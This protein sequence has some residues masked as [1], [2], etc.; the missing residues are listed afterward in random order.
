MQETYCEREMDKGA[1]A[2]RVGS[3]RAA[4]FPCRGARA[5][6]VPGAGAERGRLPGEGPEAGQGDWWAALGVVM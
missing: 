5:A 2:G 4:R 1:N 3:G 6:A